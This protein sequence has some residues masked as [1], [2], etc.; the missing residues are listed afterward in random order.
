LQNVNVIAGHPLRTPGG[1][2]FWNSNS[3]VQDPERKFLALVG[4]QCQIPQEL[5]PETALL[6][7]DES[8]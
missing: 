2:G 4:T 6:P 8:A 5:A 7:L 3:L 1:G